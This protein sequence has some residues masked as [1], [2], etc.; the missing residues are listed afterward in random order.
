[1]HQTLVQVF[2][3]ARCEFGERDRSIDVVKR[4]DTATRSHHPITKLDAIRNIRAD[5]TKV[6]VH[7]LTCKFSF[8]LRKRFIELRQSVRWIRQVSMFGVPRHVAL[9]KAH[10]VSARAESANQRAK[11]R[12]VSVAPRGGNG[13]AEDNDVQ[14]FSHVPGILCATS[15]FSVSLWLSGQSPQRHREHRGCTEKNSNLSHYGILHFNN[16]FAVKQSL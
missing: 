4:F 7:Q 6:C 13:K 2:S 10:V 15:V 9:E 1:M 16:D 11:R 8:Q 3:V 12:C 14:R 5:N